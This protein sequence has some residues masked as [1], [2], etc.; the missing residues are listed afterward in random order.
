M[1]KHGN[2]QLVSFP[3]KCHDDVAL[4]NELKLTA[5]VNINLKKLKINIRHSLFGCPYGLPA[6]GITM[7]ERRTANLI[8]HLSRAHSKDDALDTENKVAKGS[9]RP[10]SPY[11]QSN[12]SPIGS[13]VEKRHVNASKIGKK[14]DDAKSE[15]DKE[16]YSVVGRSHNCNLRK[17]YMH[18]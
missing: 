4:G 2:C 10:L 8:P 17:T 14:S 13:I 11:Y 18:I 3:T 16:R 12:V 9:L 15:K 6:I 7:C 1:I 5:T